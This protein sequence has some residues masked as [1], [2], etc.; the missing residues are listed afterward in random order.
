MRSNVDSALRKLPNYQSSATDKLKRFISIPKDKI[1]RF[2]KPYNNRS[3]K[4][5]LNTDVKDLFKP[6]KINMPNF[7]STTKDLNDVKDI[8]NSSNGAKIT[9][10]I[11]PKQKSRGRDVSRYNPRDEKEILY[12]TNT[13][14]K[15]NNV[16]KRNGDYFIDLSE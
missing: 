9:Y 3:I 2:I 14:F 7:T 4:Q 6:R 5:L 11:T 12:P 8:I 13:R 15:I 10:Q 1:D 16:K